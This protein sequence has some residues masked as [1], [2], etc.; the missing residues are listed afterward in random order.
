MGNYLPPLLDRDPRSC[1]AYEVAGNAL[2]EICAEWSVGCAVGDVCEV[3]VHIMD[4]GWLHYFVPE[5][6]PIYTSSHPAVGDTEIFLMC[7]EEP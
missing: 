7:E 4:N 6:C 5:P 1:K 2:S 3:E